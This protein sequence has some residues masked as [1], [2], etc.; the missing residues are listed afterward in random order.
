MAGLFK[1]AAK[2]GGT[3]VLPDNGPMDGP[4]RFLVPEEGRFALIGDADG[5]YL[6]GI[7]FCFGQGPFDDGKD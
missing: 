5:G 6:G 2:I 3:P 1:P 4:S 7:C